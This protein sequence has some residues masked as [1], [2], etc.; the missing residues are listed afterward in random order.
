MNKIESI[1]FREEVSKYLDYNEEIKG[2]FLSLKVPKR[3]Y[4]HMGLNQYSIENLERNILYSSTPMN[5]NDIFDSRDNI[6]YYDISL[7]KKYNSDLF[8]RSELEIAKRIFYAREYMSKSFKIICFTERFNSNLMWAHYSEN[9]TG[10][11]V[12]F[13]FQNESIEKNIVPV[14]YLD[15]PIDTIK[16]KEKS[17]KNEENSID[18]IN[19]INSISKSNE[20]SYEKEWR[21][22]LDF[23]FDYSKNMEI[24]V[25]KKSISRIILGARFFEYLKYINKDTLKER[26]ECMKSLFN[27]VLNNE[28]GLYILVPT[29]NQYE[30]YEIKVD[31]RAVLC[32]L[33]NKKRYDSM[34]DKLIKFGE[35]LFIEYFR[36]KI[37]YKDYEVYYNL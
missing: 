1:E 5:Y 8:K 34:K 28:I 31:V 14:C 18:K 25:P 33:N 11:C 12:E 3:L 23:T 30:L 7:Y 4:K 26:V 2:Y 13:N 36:N 32:I 15:K 24:K 17:C 27:Y 22:I 35:N 20:W 10:I 37:S 16:L 9:H 6:F 29:V 19:L 21:F